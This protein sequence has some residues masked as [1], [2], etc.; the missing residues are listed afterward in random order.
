MGRLKTWHR[1]ALAIALMLSVLAGFS[2]LCLRDPKINF[3]PGHGPVGWIVFPSAADTLAHPIAYID[4]TFRRAFTLEQQPRAAQLRISASKRFQLKINGGAVETGTIRNWKDV[5]TVDV[6]PFLRSGTNVIE[7]RVFND[8]AP[9]ALWL[10][11]ITDGTTVRADRSWEASFAGST[12]RP[13]VN[14]STPKFPGPGNPAAAGEQTIKVLWNIWP[15]WLGFLS[16]AV[17]IWLIG[18]WQLSRSSRSAADTRSGPWSRIEIAMLVLLAGLW[19]VLFWNNGRFMPLYA[20]FDSR[21]HLEY[22]R[23]IQERWTVPL[24]TEGFEMFHPP[25]YYALSAALLSL[26][27]LSVNDRP[28]ILVLRLLT[29]SI[30]VSHFVFV[31]LS[32]RFLFPN[33]IGRQFVGLLLAAFLPMQLYLS[34]YVTNETLAATLVTV[35][36]YFALRVL[37]IKAASLSGYALLGFFLGA[38]ILTKATA[39]LLLPPLLVMLAAKMIVER[40]SAVIWLRT[41]GVTFSICFIVCS[42]YYIWI[43]HHFG[44]PLVGNWNAAATRFA[45]WQDPGYH[46]A[47]DF[48]RFGR[49][50][51][52]P[53]FS[54]LGGIADGVYSTLWGDGLWGGLSDLPSRTPWNYELMVGGYLLALVP[55]ILILTGVGGAV[56]QFFRK[57]SAEWFFLFAFCALVACAFIF[58]TLKVA[59][60]A[61]IKAFYGLSALIP[62]CCFAAIGWDTLTRGHRGLRF[63]LGTLLLVWAMNSFASMWIR[64]SAAQHVYNAARWKFENK[65][66]SAR[67]EAVKAVDADSTNAMAHRFLSLL[68]ADVGRFSEALEHAERAVQLAP[69][70]S[71][72][73]MQLSAVLMEQGQLERA[74]A[75]ARRAIE[76]GSENVAAYDLLFTCLRQ[77]QRN[78][79]AINVARDG[80]AVS[81]FNAELHYRLG[82]AAGQQGDFAAAANQFVYALLLRPDRPEPEAKLRVTLPLLAKIPNGL[83]QLQE[84]VPLASDSPNVLDKL[85]WL[86]ATHPDARL[87]DGA[88]AV[89]LAERACALTVRKIPALLATLAA[90][91]AEQ[92]NFPDAIATVQ[93]ALSLAKSTGDANAVALG[94]NLLASFQANRPYR[95][96]SSQ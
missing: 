5:S 32:L 81:P 9:P 93:E 20:G 76:L 28:G 8:N 92:G 90:A 35:A 88:E 37:R 70:S 78:D 3:L 43:W 49:S 46:T 13:A 71:D 86:F 29:M 77:L 52:R 50:L 80:L 61:Q 89:R 55:T 38:A 39:V 4:T 66:E 79:D 21:S 54:G 63:V 73:H 74:V 94:E 36:I 7:V 51:V 60:Y 12:W 75:E 84:I 2:R 48:L 69:F 42:W 18:R 23:Y 47:A 53:L 17:A 19:A 15:I 83:R 27:R 65:L 33:Q 45:W 14:A 59:S 41:L 31:F 95:E 85:A 72:N 11:L 64:D 44:T 58:M 26:C 30:G 91:Y 96:Q 62:L 22:I 87:R 57:P 68:S 34:H 40:S 24:P 1:A 56:Y 6:V 25:L 67:S 16:I 82:L 10:V